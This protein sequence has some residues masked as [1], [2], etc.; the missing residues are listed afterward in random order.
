MKMNSLR[1]KAQHSIIIIKEL[2]KLLS[3]N[4]AFQ[5]YFRLDYK[6]SL[7]RVCV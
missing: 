7:F 1:Q 3:F 4:I 2:I 6:S 5:F